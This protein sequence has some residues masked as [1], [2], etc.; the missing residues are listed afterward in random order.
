MREYDRDAYD[1]A[2]R[3]AVGG[4]LGARREARRLE[5]ME[6]VSSLIPA[7]VTGEP[8]THASATT[9]GGSSDL[10]SPDGTL[11]IATLRA[12]GAKTKSEQ[13]EIFQVEVD[14]IIVR[15]VFEDWFR[16]SLIL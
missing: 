13:N 8:L 10:I 3:T 11:N 7:Q 1:H 14:L 6:T 9:T 12:E 2:T 15:L 5:A 16:I 4:S